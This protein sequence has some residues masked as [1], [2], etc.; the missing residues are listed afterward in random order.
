MLSKSMFLLFLNEN[1][2]KIESSRC[3]FIVPK[4]PYFCIHTFLGLG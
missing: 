1:P 4:V 3:N 2:D